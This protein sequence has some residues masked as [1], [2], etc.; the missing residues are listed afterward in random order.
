MN[1][2]HCDPIDFSIHLDQDTSDS[3][4]REI[5]A[6]LAECTRCRDEAK[7]W[8]SIDDL[9]RGEDRI[10]VPPFQWQ[11][12]AAQMKTNTNSNMRRHF[13]LPLPN[14][15]PVWSLALAAIVM[16]VA[17]WS[18]LEYRRYGEEKQLL[19]AISRYASVEQ[20]QTG[21][22]ENPFRIPNAADY[23]NESNPFAARR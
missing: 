19:L 11:R 9:F 23:A 20:S 5:S 1:S 10:E 14:W 17:V 13:R 22:D 6:H 7:N 8:S 3:R 2:S 4:Y 18:G 16:I 12:I 21:P 15:K